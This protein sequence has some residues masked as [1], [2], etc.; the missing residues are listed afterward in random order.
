MHILRRQ[1]GLGTTHRRG[2]AREPLGPDEWWA[3]E[4]AQRLGVARN[5]LIYWM[6]QGLVRARKESGGWQ[7]WIVWADADGLKRLHAYG[8]RD[9]AAE[10]R[11]RWTA[12]QT[13]TDHQKGTTP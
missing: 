12:A 1:L 8:D 5:S 13:G 6:D 4:L 7:R 9:I 3:R 10:Q 11:R 2:Q